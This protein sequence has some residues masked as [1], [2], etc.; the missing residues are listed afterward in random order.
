MCDLVLFTHKQKDLKFYTNKFFGV[1]WYQNLGVNEDVY[2][3]NLILGHPRGAR[4]LRSAKMPATSMLIVH[5]HAQ[6]MVMRRLART[7]Q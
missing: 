1:N 5:V 3:S 2:T 6:C 7:A 4:A